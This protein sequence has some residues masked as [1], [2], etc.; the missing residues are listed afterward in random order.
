VQEAVEEE[1]FDLG[2]EG[3]AELQGL[4]GG[5][6]ERDGEVAGERRLAGEVE[7][8]EGEDVGGRVFAAEAAIELLHGGAGGEQD[9]DFAEEADGG[10]GCLDEAREVAL[11]QCA[12]GRSGCGC[13]VDH[14]DGP[15]GAAWSFLSTRWASPLR[16]QAVLPAETENKTAYTGA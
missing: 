15:V 12:A 10:A 9:G 5:D 7:G 11:G 2:G 4:V 3:V 1:D 13:Y 14:G 6:I 16:I 8:R